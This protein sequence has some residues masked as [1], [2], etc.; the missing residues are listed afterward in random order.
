MQDFCQIYISFFAPFRYTLYTQILGLLITCI[1][2]IFYIPK[3]AQITISSRYHLTIATMHY[4]TCLNV[5]LVLKS[6]FKTLSAIEIYYYVYLYQYIIIKCI[7]LVRIMLCIFLYNKNII[8]IEVYFITFLFFIF[9]IVTFI[10]I[11]NE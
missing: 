4:Q 11:V 1:S 7:M 8:K 9:I 5:F 6:I 2:Q 3:Q 10:G